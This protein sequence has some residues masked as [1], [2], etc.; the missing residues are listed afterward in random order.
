MSKLKVLLPWL[1]VAGG[2][3]LAFWGAWE[4]AGSRASQVRA[5]NSWE[6]TL[7]AGSVRLLP[8]DVFARLSIPRL[9]T[10]LYV[11]EGTDHDELRRGPGHLEGTAMP[12]DGG[13]CVIAG[14]RDT[15]F[16]V[17]ANIRE[18]DK[19]E[20]TT[21]RGEFVYRVSGVSIVSPDNTAVLEPGGRPVLKLITCYP[22][23]YVG[24]AP[25]RFV[26]RADLVDHPAARTLPAT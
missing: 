8:G 19:I 20:I 1:L 5:A 7:A 14:H 23:R 2:S 15:H 4:Y 11:V 13:N 17:L 24:S 10:A 21:V 26:V 25:K 9:H 3:C 22:F 6:P 18:G 16:Q 12:G